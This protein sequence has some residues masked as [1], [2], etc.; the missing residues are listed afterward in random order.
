MT[1]RTSSVVIDEIN[2]GIPKNHTLPSLAVLLSIWL[3]NASASLSSIGE[4]LLLM[5]V[6]LSM[7]FSADQ[8]RSAVMMETAR[9]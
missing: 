1:E 9:V 4:K 6:S 8:D 5:G 2:H 3:F 7:S